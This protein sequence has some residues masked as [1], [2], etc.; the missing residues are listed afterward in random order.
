MR[1]RIEA[2]CS[3][4]PE[5]ARA[6][7]RG[8]DETVRE[9]GR[10]LHQGLHV[11]MRQLIPRAFVLSLALLLAACGSSRPAPPRSSLSS[12]LDK[13]LPSI[14]RTALDGTRIDTTA[15]RG[16]VVVVK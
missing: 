7:R 13:P 10:G 1:Q 9:R 2:A 8:G 15:L 11:R 5:C 12:L 16:R 14:A 3:T 6:G 4:M